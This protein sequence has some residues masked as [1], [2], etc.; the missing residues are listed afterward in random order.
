MKITL[1]PYLVHSVQFINYNLVQFLD[2][3]NLFTWGKAGAFLGY[4]IES[5]K[6]KQVKPR[7]VQSLYGKKIRQ[8]A[9][10]RSHTL[11]CDEDG[12]VYSFGQ[13]KFGELGQGHDKEVFEPLPISNLTNICKVVCGRH[14]SAALDGNVILNR[15]IF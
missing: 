10:G 5:G 12:Q 1:L 6:T 15:V 8:V 4:V 2:D 14:H 11:A 13:N 3:G 7:L 9:C